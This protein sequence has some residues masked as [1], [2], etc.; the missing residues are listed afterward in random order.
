MQVFNPKNI[1]PDEVVKIINKLKFYPKTYEIIFQNA[2][3]QDWLAKTDQG[4]ITLKLRPDDVSLQR[5]KAVNSYCK[6]VN[7]PTA[8]I[9]YFNHIS[10]DGSDY[11]ILV[12]KNSGIPL[13]DFKLHLYD[14]NRVLSNLAGICLKLHNIPISGFGRINP[15][16]CGYLK[17]WQDF[18]DLDL[19]LHINTLKKKGLL[20]PVQVKKTRK[21]LST[22]FNNCKIPLLLHGLLSTDSVFINNRL[23]ITTISNFEQ[24]LSGDPNYDLAG[25]LIYEGTDRTKRLIKSYYLLGGTV[26]WDSPE[27]RKNCL[28]RII[29]TIYWRVNNQTFGIPYLKNL[30]HQII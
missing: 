14:Y 25:F 23:E 18:L 17:S 16:L 29:S 19:D 21:I 9:R 22:K 3:Q 27:F 13:K 26:E 4:Y 8:K 11:W 20:N 15:S 5:E 6:K 30:M 10:I 28:R 1:P 12:E 2:Q 24:S 7:L